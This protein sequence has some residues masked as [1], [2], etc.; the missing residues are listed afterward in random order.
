[1]ARTVHEIMSSELL[2]VGADSRADE[3]LDLILEFG[4]TAVPVLDAEGRPIG[5]SSL[6]DVVRLGAKNAPVTT[7]ATTIAM[8]ASITA[9]AETM[10]TTNRHHLVVVGSDGKAVGMVST[11]DVIRALLGRP[12][13]HPPKFARRDAE[14]GMSWS[15]DEV[16]GPSVA[17]PA[18]PGE[19][20]ILLLVRGGADRDETP[21]W[22]EAAASLRA[23][24]RELV[25]DR[26]DVVPRLAELLRAGSLRFRHVVVSE[27]SRRAMVVQ[28]LRDRIAHAPPPGGS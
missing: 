28:R 22:A 17:L 26:P 6:R 18:I 15:N 27:E 5:V 21:V 8:N 12:V 25:A 24:V 3:T 13:T 23:R 14:L 2:S 7:P 19:P 1:M 16:L 11:L 20:G 4:V 10:A 9:A